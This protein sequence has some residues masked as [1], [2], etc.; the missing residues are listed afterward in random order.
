M[1]GVLV[2]QSC[3]NTYFTNLTPL[4]LTSFP[5]ELS[6]VF[7]QKDVTWIE[8]H[9]LTVFVVFFCTYKA[10][11]HVETLFVQFNQVRTDQNKP[12]FLLTKKGLCFDQHELDYLG[13]IKFLHVEMPYML[14]SSLVHLQ[15]GAINQR[16]WQSALYKVFRFPKILFIQG[17][18]VQTITNLLILFF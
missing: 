8:H 7:L 15:I 5:G 6:L 3:R 10:F 16:Q 1:V 18:I 14:N 2:D 12:P 11:R 4:L 9:P 17:Y 13:R